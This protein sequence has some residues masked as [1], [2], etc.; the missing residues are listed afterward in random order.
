[1]LRLRKNR[2]PG[3]YRYGL[4]TLL[5]A[6]AVLSADSLCADDP[7][8]LEQF[9]SEDQT[10]TSSFD[11]I[12]ASLE[13]ETE[14]LFQETRS[15][16]EYLHLTAQQATQ[17]PAAPV[18]AP[19]STQPGT[20]APAP[21]TAAPA[22]RRRPPTRSPRSR[23][24]R[25]V[26]LARV[27]NMFGD[28]WG[29]SPILKFTAPTDAND[30]A[31]DG[32]ID[33]QAQTPLTFGG[34]RMKISENN[35]LLPNHR[36]Y[37]NYNHYH[38][39][40]HSVFADPTDPEYDRDLSNVDVYTLGVERPLG[41]SEDWSVEL[42]MPIYGKVTSGASVFDPINIDLVDYTASEGG[43][44][45]ISVIFKNVLYEEEST[46]ISGGLGITIPTAEDVSIRV[47]RVTT[48]FMNQTVDVSPWIG[49]SGTPGDDWFWQFFT[50]L[51]IPLN[52]SA[53]NYSSGIDPNFVF[54]SVPDAGSL[55][56]FDLQT[57]FTAEVSAG[58]WLFRDTESDGIT[59]VALITELH[60]TTALNDSDVLMG[61]A[62]A[63]AGL[64]GSD[65]M[66]MVNQPGYRQHI[67][68]A[69]I[70]LHFAV[71][72]NVKVRFGQVFP[73]RQSFDQP[74][75]TESQAQVEISY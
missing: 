27:P 8:S 65:I 15:D 38:N 29:G 10:E 57:L 54:A 2:I 11:D 73:M 58:H 24:R 17:P 74:F 14:Q 39:A 19:G 28:F 47:R 32:S 30:G 68:N 12:Y 26:R 40:N 31:F 45:N 5:L 67:A 64:T 35:G 56:R 9:L 72:D 21:P 75:S 7:V 41:D 37:F 59:G 71:G 42:R 4:T 46:V 23:S 34:R 62:G 61:T 49:I 69:T 66:L 13:D 53:V 33:G 63:L 22:P 70:G 36:I 20:P 1:M 18:P 60:Y 43:I 51:N 6:L 16:S 50:Q 52:G 55:G 48:E 25:A 44:G 3:G